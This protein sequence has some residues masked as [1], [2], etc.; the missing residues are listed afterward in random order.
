MP[1]LKFTIS[2]TMHLT[3]FPMHNRNIRATR[4]LTGCTCKA[5]KVDKLS[6]IKMK[7]E[8][9]AHGHLGDSL[10]TFTVHIHN[11]NVMLISFIFICFITLST[12]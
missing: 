2:S 6:V 8:L 9:S 12:Q 3:L 4:D 1:H 5:L 10:Y 11:P 7:T